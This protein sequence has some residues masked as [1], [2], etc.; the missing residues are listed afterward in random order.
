[1]SQDIL[2]MHDK[3][4]G[5]L[6][7]DIMGNVLASSSKESFKRAFGTI[8]KKDKEYGPSLAIAMLALANQVKD[9]FGEPQAIITTFKHCKA[10]LIPSQPDQIIVGLVLERSADVEDFLIAENNIKAL[11]LPQ[12]KKEQ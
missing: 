7:M 12:Y 3:V 4:L 1:M 11:L 6:I 5:I 8:S 2:S 10:M 9:I